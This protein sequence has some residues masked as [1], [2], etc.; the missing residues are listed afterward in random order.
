MDVA[1]ISIFENQVIPMG[2]HNLSK[3]FKPNLATTRVFSLGTKFIPVW[4]SMKIVKPFAKFED[5][6][7]RMSNKVFFEE[8]S[9]GTFV[10]NKNFHVKENF[11][12]TIG[13]QK[14]TLFVTTLEMVLH[15]HY[16]AS[17]NHR[18]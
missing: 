18:Y 6:R 7:R 17:K 4:K 12:Q 5:F 16:R 14:L 8:I 15:K 9:P 10:R 13:T 3:S 11:G 1:P 2:L